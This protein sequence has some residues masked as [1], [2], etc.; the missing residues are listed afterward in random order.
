MTKPSRL[1]SLALLAVALPLLFVSS[2]AGSAQNAAHPSQQCM[3]GASSIGPIV[4]K[5][6]RVVGGSTTPHTQACQP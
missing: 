1:L 4:L 3:H 2:S 5:N 6:G